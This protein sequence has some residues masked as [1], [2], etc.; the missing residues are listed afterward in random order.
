MVCSDLSDNLVGGTLDPLASLARLRLVCDPPSILF[1][2]Q[3][4][5]FC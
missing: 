2:A 4:T 5:M 3:Y 1:A